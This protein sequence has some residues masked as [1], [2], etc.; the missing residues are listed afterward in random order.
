V[1]INRDTQGEILDWLLDRNLLDELRAAAAILAVVMSLVFP[2]GLAAIADPHPGVAVDWPA[3][4]LGMLAVVAVTVG[5]AA[6]PSWKAARAACRAEPAV[7]VAAWSAPARALPV[8][9]AL[10]ARLALQQASGR[11]RVPVRSMVIASAVGVLGLTA[12]LVFTSSFDYLLATPRLYGVSFDAMV[13]SLEGQPVGPAE[14]AAAADPAVARWA[15]SYAG[16][17]IEVNGIQVGVITTSGGP[18]AMTVAV[19]LQGRPPGGPGEIALGAR[20]L[21]VAGARI[22]GTVRVWI[23]GMGQPATRMVVGTAIFPAVADETQLGTGAEMTTQG[24]LGLVSPGVPLPPPGVLVSFRAGAGATGQHATGSPGGGSPVLVTK[25]S[26][27]AT[28]QQ[29]L[30]VLAAQADQAG[31]FGVEGP[32]TPADLINFG[33]IQDLPLLLGL[34]LGA[35]ALMT[36]GHL[37][38]TSARRR[39]RDLAVLRALG[40]TPRQVR[41]VVIWMA[42]MYAATA[43]LVGVPMGIVAGRLAWDAFAVRLGLPPVS[44][45]QPAW[46]AVLIAGALALAALVAAIPARSATRQAPAFLL[47]AE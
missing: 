36:L 16:V 18:G 25:G 6:W 13:F 44:V 31:P 47:R 30:T 42:V 1:Q 5:C 23:P 12:A 22:G 45:I 26:A 19:P 21:A 7:Q 8:A 4:G 32:S 38:L 34:A 43:L 9:V 46:V 10:G 24:L 14:R 2:V 15:P 3:L 40:L 11:T 41:A 33:Q 35:L 29:K 37:L 27:Q 39:R 20:T 28:E 17:P